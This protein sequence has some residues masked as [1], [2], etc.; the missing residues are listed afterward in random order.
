[1]PIAEANGVL[2]YYEWHG[3]KSLPVLVLSHSLGTS[4]AMWKPQLSALSDRFR[5]L[6]YDTRGHGS[7]SVPTGPYNIA[8]LAGDLL[9]LLDTLEVEQVNFC[10]LSMGG[11][12]GQWLA[13]NAPNRLNKLVLANT[14]AKIGTAEM[15]NTRIEQASREGLAPTIPTVLERWFTPGYRASHPDTIASVRALLEDANPQ[16][17]MGCSAA[18]RDADFRTSLTTVT[19]PTLVISG[20]FDGGTTPSDGQFIANIIPGAKYAELPAAHISSIEAA[21]GFNIALNNFVSA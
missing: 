13:I 3:D 12:I 15:W 4:H 8:E 17:Y 7:T 2:T 1:M 16:G 14:A 21:E 18:I 10:G 11:V 6:A 19:V 9:S 20:T 5:L